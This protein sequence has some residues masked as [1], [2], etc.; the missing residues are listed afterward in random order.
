MAG[1]LRRAQSPADPAPTNGHAGPDSGVR[2]RH[3]PRDQARSP[4]S[5]TASQVKANRAIARHRGADPEAIPHQDYEVA[6]EE[7]LT[8][9]HAS[10]LID[11]LNG[12]E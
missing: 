5:A 12:S 4:E 6:R 10:A 3:A 11:Q 1:P 7:E 2:F 9:R 8:L